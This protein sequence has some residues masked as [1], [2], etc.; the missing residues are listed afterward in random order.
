MSSFKVIISDGK[1]KLSKSEYK[2]QSKEKMKKKRI[3]L[4]YVR[5]WMSFFYAI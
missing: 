1:I 3:L 2:R 5:K 4:K